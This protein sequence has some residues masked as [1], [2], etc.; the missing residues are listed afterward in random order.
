MLKTVMEYIRD[1]VTKDGF[2]LTDPG[3]SNNNIMDTLDPVGRTNL[4]NKMDNMIK[5]I[6]EN[7]ENIKTYFPVNEKFEKKEESSE[8]TY[9]TKG[10]TVISIPKNNERF[11]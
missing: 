2:K 5:R 4:S 11:G 9:G 7:S 8:K 6:E 10:A 3:N 1:N